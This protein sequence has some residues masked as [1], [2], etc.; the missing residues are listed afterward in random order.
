[1]TNLNAKQ[2]SILTADYSRINSNLNTAISALKA[3]THKSNPEIEGMDFLQLKNIISI[4][5]KMEDVTV[6]HKAWDN[7]MEKLNS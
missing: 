1:M 4:L 5:E 2:V 7:F 3:I 6:P